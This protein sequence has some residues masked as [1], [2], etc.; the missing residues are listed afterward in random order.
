MVGMVEVFEVMRKEAVRLSCTRYQYADSSSSRVA[1]QE[2]KLI[3]S[4]S[5]TA[6]VKGGVLD[7]MRV[8]APWK[9]RASRNFW[10]HVLRAGI[11]I[12]APRAC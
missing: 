11:S 8:P 4:A 12:A 3:V 7:D 2:I 9:G 1:R 6:G 10:V 5:R